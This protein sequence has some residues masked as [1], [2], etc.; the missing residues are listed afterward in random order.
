MN[1]YYG[2]SILFGAIATLFLYLGHDY[3]EKRKELEDLNPPSA[4]FRF[5]NENSIFT[6]KNVT[7]SVD[8]SKNT[9]LIRISQEANFINIDWKKI[10]E[11]Y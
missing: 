10:T 6:K 1:M 8:A 3:K 11:K 7:I 4:T 2:L 5:E 9:E